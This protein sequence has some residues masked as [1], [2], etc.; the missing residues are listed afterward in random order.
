MLVF[1]K[2]CACKKWMIPNQRF[3]DA[4]RGI[5]RDQ[6]HKIG[7]AG[8][9]DTTFFLVSLWLC[10]NSLQCTEQNYWKTALAVFF[11][12]YFIRNHC[13]QQCDWYDARKKLIWLLE[14]AIYYCRM[15][16]T[17]SQVFDRV[18]TTP[19]LINPLH[20]LTLSLICFLCTLSL[21][22]ENI[23]KPWSFLTFSGG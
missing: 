21:P 9:F 11:R 2:F 14:K 12:K 18:L 1:R 5:E 3:F 10:R 19:L 22:P 17:L 7:L 6:L 4:S 16:K 23:R 15:R 8:K 13:N 20:K